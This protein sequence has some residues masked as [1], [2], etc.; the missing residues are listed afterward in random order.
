[1]T[2]TAKTLVRI[3]TAAV[4][5]GAIGAL[6][7]RW[8]GMA[9]FRA[10]SELGANMWISV[11]LWCVFS[12][13][14]SIAAKDSA[15]TKSAESVWSRQWHLILVNGALL[16]LVF[17]VPGL[18]RRFL[19]ASQWIVVV[20]LVI[21]AAFVLFAVWARRHLGSN[22]SGEVRIAAGHQLV[23]S[24][25]YGFVRHP[26]YTAV[27]GMYCGTALV[28]GE[29]HAPIALVIVT[30]AYWR[31]IRLEE[32]ALEKTF[33]ADFDEYRRDTWALV[34]PLY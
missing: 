20:G 22:W 23:R 10:H 14:W 19:P 30:L 31:K 7:T 17:P 1:M 18:T 13:Y 34:P 5:G 9:Q 24:G 2:S 6:L 16:L 15:P 26:I 4:V 11:A 25:P 8:K 28:S 12:I 3:L 33:G 29:I 21:Q 32:Q 27:L